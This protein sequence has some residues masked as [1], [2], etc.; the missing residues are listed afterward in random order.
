MAK[1]DVDTCLGAAAAL[2]L[3]REGDLEPESAQSVIDALDALY[4]LCVWAEREARDRY[5]DWS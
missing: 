4:S 2:S 5:P 1:K 3:W